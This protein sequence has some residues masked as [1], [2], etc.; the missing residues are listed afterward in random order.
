MKILFVVPRFHT[1]QYQMIKTLQEHHHEVFF[2]VASFGPTED[3]SLLT[4]T[5]LE[6]SKL[7][8]LIEKIFGTGGINC[9]NYF[10]SFRKYWKAF[11]A[12]NPDVVVIRNPYRFFSLLVAFFSLFTKT[13]VVFYTQEELFR[14]RTRQTRLK[15]GL[16]IRFFRAAWMIP[17]KGNEDAHTSKLKHQYY[18]PI[19][20]PTR[21]FNHM[22]NGREND[23]P[24]ILMVGKYHQERKKHLLLINAINQ[25]KDKYQF[26][27]TIVG[28]CV[29]KQQQEKFKTIQDTVQ[30][31]GLS[32]IIELKQN[33]PF[34]QMEELYTS[35]DLFVLPAI[36]EQYGVSVTEALGYGLPVICTDTCG[37]RFNIKNGENGF[38]VKS[39]S[40][41]ELTA[42]LE[43]LVS[44]KDKLRE[45]SEHSLEYVQ[46][47][48]SG[49][50]FY[51]KFSDLLQDRFQLQQFNK[52]NFKPSFERSYPKQIKL[53][54]TIPQN[55]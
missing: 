2:H 31:L 27:V 24:K 15:Q 22:R 13:K 21:T 38:V 33:V 34:K 12:L 23:V 48:L 30:K 11:R 41:E 20:I 18:V 42:A 29:R 5:R 37:A 28:E 4:P 51:S 47:N 3:Y 49:H 39:D 43:V 8:L 53:N 36:N 10:P 46:N 9:P 1:N 50:V 7:S 19:P 32:D 52:H 25:L 55:P 16:T 14:H 44:S 17:I 40:L 35:H 54:N 6:Q 45:M 26:K